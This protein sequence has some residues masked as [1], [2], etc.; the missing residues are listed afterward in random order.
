MRN[1][2]NY[3]FKRS[4]AGLCALIALVCNS[5]FAQVTFTEVNY[6]SD[7]TRLAGDWVELYNTGSM[8][9]DISNWIFSDADQIHYFAIPGGTML[10]PGAYLVLSNDT[11]NFKIQYPSVNNVIGQFNFSLGNKGDVLRLFD[12]QS[13]LLLSMTYADSAGWPKAADGHGRTMEIRNPQGNIS[14]PSN[15]YAGCMG[16]SPGAA[17]SPCTEP[18]VFSEVN[19]NS[20]ASA[21]TKDWVE[22]YNASSQAIDISNW[23]LRDKN[24][25]SSFFIQAGTVLD[26]GEYLVL[27]GGLG[28]FVQ[29]F[30]GATN[31][32]GDFQ[33]G[34]KNSK[35][36]I[37]LFN[38][39]GK[40]VYSLA[41]RSDGYWPT[42]PDGG[43]YTLEMLDV[44]GIMND[45]QNWFAGC[46]GGS[47]G[48][49]YSSACGMLAVE[50]HSNETGIAVYPN[51]F[52]T[53]A[54]IK[55]DNIK[56]DGDIVV[57]ITDALGR[58]V[59]QINVQGTAGNME[60]PL[61]RG[62][63][64]EGIYLY[65]VRSNGN[66]LGSGKL[67]IRN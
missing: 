3:P 2:T 57:S 9:V 23:V 5:A 32:Q 67:V 1:F 30:P 47:P 15:W 31:V 42:E 59:R 28:Y 22:L 16:G 33:F 13:T 20:D 51:P 65:S 41:Y 12:A 17:P 53:E 7:T 18:I 29:F 43:G 62:E 10:L 39:Q 40:L 54:V 52:E 38:G 49:A 37:R 55:L 58:E 60:I 19:Y 66:I 25:S 34:L 48:R 8:P 45:G 46:F 6:H 27:S 63:L 35:D 36:V 24:D 56:S 61:K 14:D 64:S 44:N 11:M 4:L 21:D 26:P 50:T